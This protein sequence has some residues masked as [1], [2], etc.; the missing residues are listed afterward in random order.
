M[1]YFLIAIAVICI[2]F[3]TALAYFYWINRK[4]AKHRAPIEP[5]KRGGKREETEDALDSY[6]TELAREV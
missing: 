6:M 2:A 5:R 3:A 4:P 1:I